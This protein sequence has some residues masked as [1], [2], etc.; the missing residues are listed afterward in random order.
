MFLLPMHAY[1]YLYCIVIFWAHMS[2][3]PPIT[4]KLSRVESASLRLGDGV[5]SNSMLE[6]IKLSNAVSRTLKNTRLILFAALVCVFH[7]FFY[8]PLMAIMLLIDIR[9]DILKFRK[10]SQHQSPL[11]SE[12][13]VTIIRLFN[14]PLQNHHF[15]QANHHEFII[16]GPWHPRCYVFCNSDGE[17]SFPSVDCVSSH[18]N[19]CCFHDGCFIDWIGL[20]DNLQETRDFPIKHGSF[21]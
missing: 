20:R 4:T 11:I 14:V 16:Y 15:E 5:A 7:V 13:S 19:N 1:I 6:S 18:L 12:A 10:N 17:G 2:G 21:L 3:L 8:N 9:F